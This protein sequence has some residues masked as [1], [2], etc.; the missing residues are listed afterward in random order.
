MCTFVDFIGSLVGLETVTFIIP[1]VF[2][3]LLVA[4]LFLFVALFN[5]L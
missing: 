4:S 2:M 5:G 3:S 1:F